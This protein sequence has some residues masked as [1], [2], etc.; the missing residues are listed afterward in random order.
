MS[1]YVSSLATAV[2]EYTVTQESIV[3]L[4]SSYM[5]LSS[6]DEKLL[7]RIYQATGI[8]Y[9]HSVISDYQ[10]HTTNPIF[11]PK[12]HLKLAHF[13]AD[14]VP[15]SGDKMAW[16]IGNHGF[17]MVL[18]SYVP[19]L[20]Q[21]GIKQFFE[22]LLSQ[23]PL[24]LKEIDYFAIHPGGLNILKGCE[25]AL[26]IP[27]HKIKPSYDVLSQY[28]NMSSATFLFVLDELISSHVKKGKINILGCAF[29]PGLTM[30]SISIEPLFK[31]LVDRFKG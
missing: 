11:F 10:K 6:K 1:A 15:E 13:H 20:I 4:L 14:I 12:S 28:G 18:D 9:R 23:S 29:G 16:H 31:A 2:P 22:N 17:E 7:Q 26:S 21:N 27:Q 8:K 5:N 19:T 24:T 3:Q 30:E 25:K